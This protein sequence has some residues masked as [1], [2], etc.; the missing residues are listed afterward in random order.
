L[1]TCEYAGA[2][3]DK[4]RSHPWLDAEGNRACRYYDLTATPA[5]I[6]TSLEDFLPW[7]HSAAV[8]VFYKLLE[9]L[10]HPKSALESNDC[11]FTGPHPSEEPML[12]KALTCSGRVMV[13]FR[14][15]E[16]NT[17]R[18]RVEWL[19]NAIHHELLATDRSFRWGVVGTTLL[20]VRYLAL[21]GSDAQLGWQLMISFWAWGSSEA[22]TLRN[23]GRLFTNLTQ[24]LSKV[25]ARAAS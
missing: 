3:F 20:P 1:K 2:P 25:S 8:E 7:S 4:P 19:K 15:L 16:R 22:D 9:R 17:D 18:A 5:H 13:L 24:A 21:R 12:G 23:L 10:N 14:A 11:E 6:R